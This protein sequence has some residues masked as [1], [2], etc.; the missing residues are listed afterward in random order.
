LASLATPAYA[1]DPLVTLGRQI[2]DTETFNG[3]GRT[4]KT[5]HDVAEAYSITP[6]AIDALFASDPSDP[7]FVA[8]N[9]PA[10][11]TLENS[12]LL[13]G[14]NKRALFLENVDGFGND[15]VF[16][17]AP[18]L[19]NVGLTAPYGQG[20]GVPLLRDFPLGAITQ[21]ATQTL[22]RVSGVD[23]RVPTSEELD[24]LEAYMDSIK[25]PSDGNLSID[26]M[27]AYAIELGGDAAAIQRG[28]DL[29]FDPDGL[30]Q[31]FR[32]HS[33]P[34]LADAD[35]SLGTGTGNLNFA[36]GVV[37]HPANI[38]DGCS[39]GPGDPS[40][41]LPPDGSNREFNTP[42]LLGIASTGPFFHDN[43]ADTLR[44][45]VAF[46]ATIDFLTSPAGLL[47][48]EFSAFT[49]QDTDDIT[50]FLEAI[51]VDPPPAVPSSSPWS[52]LFLV[53]LL[54]ATP[55]LAG[56]RRRLFLHG[57]PN[58]RKRKRKNA[59]NTAI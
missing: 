7:L 27:I 13:R 40:N 41:P 44:D 20:G 2:F 59:A 16:R 31:C 36:T 23:F 55:S 47:L 5:C 32:C 33:G 11:A 46:Y 53:A 54:L 38:N 26:R 56:A 10:L 8:D 9:V 30:P 50:A 17:T 3:N 18:H 22:A 58:G 15:P 49:Q 25:F 48:P 12:C 24:A 6:T 1:E 14:G 43:S 57:E 34:A 45:A 51:S 42:G 4:C 39:G 35:G 52:I 21:H 19:F 29:F 37:D 28:R